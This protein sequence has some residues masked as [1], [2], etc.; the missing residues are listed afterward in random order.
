MKTFLDRLTWVAAGRTWNGWLI[1]EL[2]W[3]TGN[4][5]RLTLNHVPGPERLVQLVVRENLSLS[6]LLQGKGSPYIVQLAADWSTGEQLLRQLTARGGW[7]WEAATS[8][9]IS[10]IVLC[11]PDTDAAGDFQRMEIIAGPGP[12]PPALVA[13]MGA[14]SIAERAGLRALSRIEQSQILTG[15]LGPHA[16]FQDRPR[17]PGY[18]HKPSSTHLEQGDPMVPSPRQDDSRPALRAELMDE[19]AHLSDDDLRRLL[20]LAR[21]LR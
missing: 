5:G 1:K 21:R 4:T 13:R 2:G 11:G 17:A 10:G 18:A 15:W 14:A 3:N 8:E 16:Y 6:W 9:T 20:D 19:I 12:V 7:E